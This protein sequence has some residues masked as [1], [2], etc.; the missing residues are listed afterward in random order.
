MYK[1][2]EKITITGYKSIDGKIFE[3]EDDVLKHEENLNNIKVFAIYA[4]SNSVPSIAQEFIGY[5]VVAAKAKHE[6]FLEEW[7][8][9]KYGKRIGYVFDVYSS[10]A[11]VEIWR[12]LEIENKSAINKEHIIGAFVDQEFEARELLE[13]IEIIHG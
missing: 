2:M 8:Y 9:E 6:L 10:H 1:K 12:Y 7:L 4:N 13:G 11:I 3:K 5:I